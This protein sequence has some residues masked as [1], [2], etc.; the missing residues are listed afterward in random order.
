MQEKCNKGKQRTNTGERL[1]PC[2]QKYCKMTNRARKGMTGHESIDDV[3]TQIKV[4]IKQ[5]SEDAYYFVNHFNLMEMITLS[6]NQT[7]KEKINLIIKNG[8]SQKS[9]RIK[10]KYQWLE[11]Y[12]NSSLESYKKMFHFS[13]EDLTNA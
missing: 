8:L 9:D 13:L 4:L 11:N 3:Y 5:S 7:Q 1:L 2:E 10:Q 6:K 12:Y